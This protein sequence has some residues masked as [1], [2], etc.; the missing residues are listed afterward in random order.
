[1]ARLTGF[2]PVAY[3]LGICRSIQLSYGRNIFQLFCALAHERSLSCYVL[4]S[5]ACALKPWRKSG[6]GGSLSK[7]A[8]RA[9]I[10][11]KLA[12]STEHVQEPWNT[13]Y[14]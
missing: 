3:R 5:L 8:H 10:S 2:E 4:R 6:V 13:V 1:M 9:Q 11:I 7:G 12:P 14:R